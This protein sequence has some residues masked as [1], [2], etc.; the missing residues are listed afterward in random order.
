M[1]NVMLTERAASKVTELRS[2]EGM[3]N[4]A[5]RIKVVGGGCSGYTYD[6]FFDEET[7]EGDLVTDS[8]GVRVVVDPMSLSYLAGTE[9]DYVESLTAAGFK[10]NNPNA[11]STCGCGTSFKA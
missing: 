3:P 10:F 2:A 8:S 9:I 5:L 1:Q 4:A 7:G 11:V 6:L